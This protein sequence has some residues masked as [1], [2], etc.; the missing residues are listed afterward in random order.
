M[1]IFTSSMG[2]MEGKTPTEIKQKFSDVSAGV[3][4]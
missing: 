2:F 3:R 4:T 1:V